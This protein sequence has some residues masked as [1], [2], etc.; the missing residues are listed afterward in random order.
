MA[1]DDQR[2]EKRT[3]HGVHVDQ[4]SSSKDGNGEVELDEASEVELGKSDG[5]ERS[6]GDGG[7]EADHGERGE[8]K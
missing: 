7:A 5:G 4:I 1:K 3:S 6:E 8:T 2:F